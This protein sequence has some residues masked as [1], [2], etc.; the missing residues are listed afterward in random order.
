MELAP[1][2][3]ALANVQRAHD[4][5]RRAAELAHQEEALLERG[6]RVRCV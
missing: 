1:P 3:Q 6:V 2:A 5:R 4:A